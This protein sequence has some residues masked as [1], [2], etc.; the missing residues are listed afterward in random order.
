MHLGL[1]ETAADVDVTC[2]DCGGKG[3]M[4]PST[5]VFDDVA[6]CALSS[7]DYARL[8]G[9]LKKAGIHT[10]ASDSGGR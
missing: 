8:I 7:E 2:P 3:Y 1:C 4:E 5:I 9:L 6:R 10:D